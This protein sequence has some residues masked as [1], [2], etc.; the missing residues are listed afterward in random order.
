MSSSMYIF[1]VSII[2]VIQIFG[3]IN[4]WYLRFFSTILQGNVLKGYFS[5]MELFV[6]PRDIDL[7]SLSLYT[8][9]GQTLMSSNNL[10]V[11]C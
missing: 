11:L 8:V 2:D 9:T 5:A 3:K 10:F 1:N 7:C 6:Y 4:P